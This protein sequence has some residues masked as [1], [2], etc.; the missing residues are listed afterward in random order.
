MKEKKHYQTTT[1]HQMYDTCQFQK[2]ENVKR[3]LR[4]YEL[5]YITYSSKS[6]QL[7]QQYPTLS[8]HHFQTFIIPSSWASVKKKNIY[9]LGLLWKV[10]KILST[11]LCTSVLLWHHALL[12]HHSVYHALLPVYMF[13]TPTPDTKLCKDLG[14][15]LFHIVPYKVRIQ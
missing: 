8:H 14:V 15:Y 3:H 13:L 1:C 5:Q 11:L 6:L 12:P 10:N 4:V 2:C 7:H 9:F